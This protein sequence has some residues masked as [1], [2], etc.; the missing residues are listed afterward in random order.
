M[1]MLRNPNA[2]REAMRHQDMAIS[3]LEN[4][5]EGFNALRRMYEDVAEP[6]MDAGIGLPA[7]PAPS[8]PTTTTPSSSTPNSAALPNPWGPPPAQSAPAQFPGF[9]FPGGM[10]GMQGMAGMPG[11]PDPSQ[12]SAMMGNPMFQQQMQSMLR[13]PQM[14]A[15]LGAMNPQLAQMMQNPQAMA[16]LSNPQFLQQMSNPANL[17]AM[18]NMQASMQQLQSSGLM[19]AL[20]GMQGQPT[21]QAPPAGLDFSSLFGTGQPVPPVA[22]SPVA[23]PAVDP[24]V[25]FASQLQQMEDMGFTDR[26]RNLQALV[27][28]QGNVN[29]AIERLL[30]SM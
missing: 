15:Q 9:P 5:P 26:P 20:P 8:T 1:Q 30:G 18:M 16:M 24:A 12:L 4:H 11:M 6:M 25:T 17:Q 29:A 13:N 21:G 28:A 3:Q 14:M 27:Q 10:S 19:P 2:M 7:T 22:S 23:A